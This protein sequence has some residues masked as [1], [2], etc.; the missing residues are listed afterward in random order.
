MAIVKFA[1]STGK[2]LSRGLRYIK[3]AEK[4]LNGELVGGHN[5]SPT[6][7]LEDMKLIKSLWNQEGGRQYIHFVQS[8]KPGE[9]EP[10]LAFFMA[11]QLV[12]CDIFKGFQIAYSTHCDRGHLH[13]HFILNSVNMDTGKKIQIGPE[14]RKQLRDFSDR[15]CRANDLSVIETPSE[16]SGTVSM[17]KLGAIKRAKAG[18]YKG[19]LYNFFVAVKETAAEAVSRDDFIERLREAGY[20][21][22]WTE[23]KK[24]ITFTDADGK[25][26]RAANL[27]K[28]FNEPLN[29]DALL[30]QFA[31]NAERRREEERR[32]RREAAITVE[33]LEEFQAEAEGLITKELEDE[34][35]EKRP[36]S[37]GECER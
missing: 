2:N 32:L 19:Y 14:E 6:T 22:V 8:F 17:A 12:K 25:K 29:K 10:D 28:S 15:C 24:N 11:E 30:L 3:N 18:D 26:V 27:E 13:N 35:A 21:T 4:T 33:E 37:R 16:I 23:N 36:P 31:Q 9:L 20:S 5:C 34:A 7:A 1:S